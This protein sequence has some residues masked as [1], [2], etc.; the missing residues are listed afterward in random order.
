MSLN[1]ETESLYIQMGIDPNVL[2]Y[3]LEI[4]AGLKDRFAEI[5]RL[6]LISSRFCMQCRRRR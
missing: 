2:R 4:E 3:G 1:Q 5:D 6:N